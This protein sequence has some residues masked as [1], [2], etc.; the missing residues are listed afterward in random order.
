M[1]QRQEPEGVERI[2][3]PNGS[4][5]IQID[6]YPGRYRWGQAIVP[7]LGFSVAYGLLIGGSHSAKD[8]VLSAAV[9][10]AFGVLLRFFTWR[11]V[12]LE[13]RFAP[14][15]VM[16]ANIHYRFADQWRFEAAPAG[17]AHFGRWKLTVMRDDG[18]VERIPFKDLL[19]DQAKYL[20]REIQAAAD[21]VRTP[22]V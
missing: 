10:F 15:S 7:A 17:F 19:P 6:P 13:V 20:G 9:L 22:A 2:D 12:R 21:P 1:E 3:G 5:L 8:G 14:G 16:I 11:R 18:V 4:I